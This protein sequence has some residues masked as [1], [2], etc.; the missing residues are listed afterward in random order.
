MLGVCATFH[1]LLN[2]INIVCSRL[3]MASIFSD[4]S[5]CDFF[6]SPLFSCKSL[7]AYDSFWSIIFFSIAVHVTDSRRGAYRNHYWSRW[8][9]LLGVV[10][11][12]MRRTSDPRVVNSAILRYNPRE[13]TWPAAYHKTHGFLRACE[14]HL[15]KRIADLTGPES[16]TLRSQ[17]PELI[18]IT[19]KMVPT[20][21]G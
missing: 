20:G 12:L 15:T 18:E 8:Q 11:N 5:I 19:D 17:V 3:K 4:G 21:S 1:F 6:K 9:A 16:R 7:I 10:P 13:T 14:A 2:Y